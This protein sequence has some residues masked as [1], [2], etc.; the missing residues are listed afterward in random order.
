MKNKVYFL[1][2]ILLFSNCKKESME[3]PQIDT[4]NNQDTTLTFSIENGFYNSLYYQYIVDESIC[5][6]NSNGRIISETV[7][8]ENSIE[9]LNINQENI[10][11][12][13]TLIRKEEY[14][15]ITSYYLFTY[16]DIGPYDINLKGFIDGNIE[17]AKANV[18]LTGSDAMCPEVFL[19]SS[20]GT[21]CSGG[22]NGFTLDLDAY[23][24]SIP[25]NIYINFQGINES[26]KRYL[27]LENLSETTVFN[28]EFINLPI[29]DNPITIIYPNNERIN[30]IIYGSI[31][32][33]PNKFYGLS[34]FLNYQD[35]NSS[36]H[37]IPENIFDKYKIKT[38]IDINDATYYS[39]KVENYIDLNYE[40]PE[41]S[42]EI[43]DRLIT[44]YKANSSSEYDY[45]KVRFKYN[46]GQNYFFWNF[47]GKND[48]EIDIRIPQIDSILSLNNSGIIID[49]LKHDYT[50]LYKYE[51]LN[52][53]E[54]FIHLD[55]DIYSPIKNS[56]TDEESIKKY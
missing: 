2:F 23:L 18:I 22:A 9:E 52:S 33:N 47:Y 27:W 48:S 37:Y 50:K 44:S 43:I 36:I 32:T 42:L 11:Y 55:I 54:D 31:S 39:L 25:D 40:L 21:A 5:L 1:A 56:I 16:L 15:D 41:L 53:Y 20:H 8:L 28:N 38:T 4:I 46:N 3:N 51:E 49:S 12:D 6:T 7:L 30:T 35:S 34:R 19:S 24:K 45:F 14:F 10:I 26:F 29:L 17:N 13:A